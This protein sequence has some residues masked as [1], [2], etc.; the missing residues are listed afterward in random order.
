M[1]RL[2]DGIDSPLDL[3][4]IDQKDLPRLAEE[5][6]KEIINVVSETGGHLASSL[7]AV[8]LAIAA[9]YVLNTPHDKVLWDVGH[10]AYAHKIL[11]G[12]KNAFKT[13]RQLGG[14]SGFPNKDESEYDI[15]TVGH[16]STSIS[17]ALGLAAA[18]DIRGTDEKVV[19]IIG[20]PHVVGIAINHTIC[21]SMAQ[22]ITSLFSDDC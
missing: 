12:R 14:V 4:K 15:F 7:G 16:S 20:L 2:L 9:H 5:I 11:T 22:H 3:K 21:C 1:E 10:Q 13:L 19:A 18:R 17:S 6:R 8:E